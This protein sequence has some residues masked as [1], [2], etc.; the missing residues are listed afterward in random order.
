MRIWSAIL[1]LSHF[2]LGCGGATEPS[3]DTDPDSIADTAADTGSSDAPIDVRDS[4]TGG[5]ADVNADPDGAEDV[6]HELPIDT[7]EDPTEDGPSDA[8]DTAADADAI[9]VHDD[10]DADI[11]P[12]PDIADAD[13]P[14]F[15]LGIGEDEFAPVVDFQDAAMAQGIQG[16]FHVWGSFQ[17]GGFDPVEVEFEATLQT[18]DE[19]LVGAVFWRRTVEEN[20][21]G[22]LEAAGITVFIA[23]SVI[24]ELED[25]S[26]WEYCGT[27]TSA[28]GF[29]DTQCAPIT[30][31]CC[32]YLD[33]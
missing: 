6:E 16:G 33:I 18:D 22:I 9:D 11:E 10:A 5:P 27:L 25:G 1:V 28:D 26:V 8:S 30:A 24:P 2:A 32:E 20:D 12:D 31:R 13:G 23:P 21:D 4:D 29:T 17:G 3:E 7:P 14:W 19:D 15:A